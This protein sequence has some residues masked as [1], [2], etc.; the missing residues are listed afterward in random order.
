[1]LLHTRRS[2]EKLAVLVLGLDN[3]KAV[4]D[5]LGHAIGDNLLRAV[6]KRLRSTLR[7]EDAIARLNS[8]EFAI[9]LSGATRPEDATLLARRLLE[10]IADP[11]LLED[12]SVVIGASI[13][14]A[15]SPGDGDDSDKLLKNADLALSRAKKDFR[16]TFSFF[17]AEMDARAQGRRKIETDLRDAIHTGVLQPHYQPLVNLSTGRITGFEALVRWPDPERGMISPA[18]FIPVAEE[19]GLIN[20]LG[21]LML[22]RACMDAARWPDDVRVA[23]NLSPLQFRVGNLLALVMDV[24]KQSGL[25]ARRLELEITE[26]LLLEKSSQVL[27][28]LHALRALGV[29]ISM[30]DFGN[31]YSSLSYLRSF[32]FDKIKVDRSFVQ[33]VDANRDAQAIIRSIVSLGKGLGVTITAEGVETEA[34]LSCLRAEG[35]HEGQGF[36]FSR[37][38]PQAEIMALLQAQRGLIMASGEG[39]A[40]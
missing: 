35:C 34:E 30:D 29:R 7:E 14:I 28:T 5:T 39:K 20:A 19:T 15:V 33:E 18:E 37:A 27:A 9:L 2:S 21:G 23:V 36:L 8:D 10:A 32:P 40:A 12:H 13:G 24:L 31:G 17:E 1:M 38:R 11:F 16:G 3:F 22:R 25:A 6:A 26:T 4:N